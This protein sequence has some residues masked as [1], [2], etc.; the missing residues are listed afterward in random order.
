MHNSIAHKHP[1]KK[2][3]GRI[4]F[5]FRIHAPAN[6]ITSSKYIESILGLSSVEYTRTP[7]PENIVESTHPE[8][9]NVPNKY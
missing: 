3:R 6:G 8:A 1:A 7:I 2:R 9:L 5:P 4:L